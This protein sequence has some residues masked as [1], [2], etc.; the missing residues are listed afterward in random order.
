MLN[1]GST[2]CEDLHLIQ[3]PP[4]GMASHG[5]HSRSQIAVQAVAGLRSVSTGKDR[6]SCLVQGH[7]DQ[8]HAFTQKDS[9]A[10]PTG[11]PRIPREMSLGDRREI[12]ASSMKIV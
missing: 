1:V 10:C 4:S 6:N 12:N 7:E 3:Q 11:E 8:E 2:V 5:P 9:L